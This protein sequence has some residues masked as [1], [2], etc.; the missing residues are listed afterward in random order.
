MGIID[1]GGGAAG[2]R[3]TAVWQPAWPGPPQWGRR[4]SR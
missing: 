4:G 3:G 1:S 2:L